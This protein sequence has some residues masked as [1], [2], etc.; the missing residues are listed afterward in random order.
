MTP[1]IVLEK[2]WGYTAFRPQQKEI[3]SSI[4]NGAHTFVILPTGGGK[5]LCYQIPG[6][7]LDG[8]C[9]VISPLIALMNDQVTNLKKEEL[10]RLL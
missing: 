5:S 9:L 7:L 8:S 10:K 6:L 4:L 2:Y 1:E 3:I